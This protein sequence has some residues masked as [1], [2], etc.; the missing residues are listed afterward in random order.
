MPLSCNLGTS[1]SWNPLGHSRPVTGLLYLYLYHLNLGTL[2]SWKPLGHSGP[3]TGLLYLYLY[4]T[5]LY[6]YSSVSW[7]IFWLNLYD[8]NVGSHAARRNFN[9]P[10]LFVFW[11]IMSDKAIRVP[12]CHSLGSCVML[13]F[14][15]PTETQKYSWF[16]LNHLRNAKLKKKQA[17]HANFKGVIWLNSGNK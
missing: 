2:T 10:Q 8:V 7:R 3:V 16:T 15:L 17:I 12:T 13:K 6:S 4:I 1:T 9:F 11:E 14:G 5:N